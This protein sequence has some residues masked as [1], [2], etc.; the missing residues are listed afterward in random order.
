MGTGVLV[1]VG[2]GVL[3]FVGTIG[4]GVYVFVGTFVG[5]VGV[6]VLEG[7]VAVGTGVFVR[8]LVGTV[9]VG[10]GVREG[11]RVGTVGVMVGVR[12]GV[13]VMVGVGVKL[14]TLP[15]NTQ[16]PQ[17]GKS[18]VRVTVYTPAKFALT[19]L[20]SQVACVPPPLS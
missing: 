13:Y 8:V 1:G 16:V 12:D 7:D 20:A 4:E 6:G 18:K 19:K 11:V 5:T 3:V 14:L 10:E 2:E 9:A 15:V 17:F